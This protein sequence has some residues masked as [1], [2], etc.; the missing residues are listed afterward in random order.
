MRLPVAALIL[1]IATA[2][3]LAC[4]SCGGRKGPA[5]TVGATT[6]GMPPPTG[7]AGPLLPPEL[8]SQVDSVKAP[9]GVDADMFGAL[10]RRLA[11]ALARQ[12]EPGKS[13]LRPPEGDVNIVPS[14]VFEDDG[15]GGVQLVW[16]YYCVGDYDQSGAVAV[17]DLT[18]LAVH[19]GARVG[20]GD[21][22]APVVDGDGNGAVGIS[23][24]TPIAV[25][26]GVTC[27]GYSVK[28][29][30]SAD[31]HFD[32][33]I[34][35]MPRSEGL[36]A[37]QGRMRFEY[38]L[39]PQA[40][41]WYRVV[42]LDADGAEG[43]PSEPVQY[44]GPG[45]APHIVSVSP[46]TGTPGAVV[47]FSAEVTGV[48][49]MSFIWGFGDGAVPQVSYDE[50]PQVTLTGAG[51][52]LCSVQAENGFGSDTY[53]FTLRIGDPPEVTG[54]EPT[55]GVAGTEV[56]FDV[57]YTGEA[58][59]Y[60]W[61]F[62]GG[63]MPDES[64]LESPTVTLTGAG[65]YDASVVVGND[66]GE[67]L[68]TFTLSV[69]ASGGEPDIVSVAPLSGLTGTQVAFTATVNG[70][71]PF[72]YSWDFGSGANPAVSNQSSPVVTLLA[73][74]EYPCGLNVVNAFG[75]DDFP[76]TLQVLG[77]GEPPV[78]INAGPKEG[79]A[80]DEVTF[81]AVVQGTPPFTYAWDFDGGATPST[82]SEEAPVAT[83][84]ATTGDYSCSLTV[85]NEGGS[86]E[87]LFTLTVKPQGDY[88]EVE[89]ND[90]KEIANPLPD[91]PID[92]WYCHLEKDVD[93]D[94]F[95]SFEAEFGDQLDVTMT[96][97]SD[98]CD[99][100]MELWNSDEEVLA[101]S[102][103]TSDSE[104][105]TYTFGASGTY[106]LRC[107]VWSSGSGGG[108]YWVDITSTPTFIDEVEDNDTIGQ[109]NSLSFPLADFNASLG[110]GGYDGDD[111]DY[112]AISA[113]TD[114]FL[115]FTLT[116]ES[117]GYNID[118]E[119][120][121]AS[122]TVLETS[123]GTGTT[124]SIT[125][126][127]AAGG[128]YYLRCF[129]V[130]G[131]GLYTLAGYLGPSP[132]WQTITVDDST[133]DNLGSYSSLVV[134]GGNPGIFYKDD[135]NSD[136]FFAYCSTADG[137]GSWSVYPV[138][139]TSE[140]VGSW[141]NG[142]AVNGKPAAAYTGN[143]GTNITFAMC[144]SAD[145]S[146]TWYTSEVDPDGI[147]DP[148]VW[149]IDGRPA[150]SFR[151]DGDP[152][153]YPAFAINS[154]AD[155]NGSW[156]RYAIDQDPGGCYYTGLTALANGNPI[157]S[158]YAVTAGEIRVSRCSNSDGSGVWTASLVDEE[159]SGE[160]GIAIVDGRPAVVYERDG[161][162]WF[163]INS[164][165]DGSGNWDAK[166][167]V[168]AVGSPGYKSLMVVDG[169]PAVAFS[170]SSDLYYALNT[171]ADGS[172]VWS[173]TKVVLGARLG[174]N[175]GLNLVTGKPAVSFQDNLDDWIGFAMM[176]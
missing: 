73:P 37:S 116:Q 145:G 22:H 125:Y 141:L 97:D 165:A 133:S 157:V 101:Y 43:V 17:A 85:S 62:G 136:V 120:L 23:D 161:A 21:P 1:L 104:H 152:T 10:S 11:K 159:G 123:D 71:P 126:T 42:P 28:M 2:L 27:D 117:T 134:T 80:N 52:Y 154:S 107:Y 155:G 44:E 19:F 75:S 91:F 175:H 65:D 14:L 109:A 16:S 153:D 40:G 83:L 105:F 59:Y 5:P 74:G 77:G 64:D 146:G 47:T 38:P 156:T 143:P 9:P 173:V 176:E 13:V 163:A 164:A 139:V 128:T 140:S 124:E 150:L 63:A 50:N 95:F 170:T 8:Q 54:V 72:E 41:K 131:A 35:V 111:V 166:Y 115:D 100:D 88:D 129:T 25:N 93:D 70:T 96:L 171:A 84:S 86:D 24:I 36:D 174:S 130:S 160:T 57:T 53:G 33:E 142:A 4:P 20:E 3:L 31:G 144:S 76:F 60:D 39:V 58:T 56:T 98:A 51:E 30:D 45:G 168:A 67:D 46:Q 49:P 78:I 158:Y 135:S 48:K 113:D 121:D 81:S 118:L 99:R 89:P 169:K 167:E 172:G 114:D 92:G 108:D 12:L 110:P 79:H 90:T 6:H 132:Y 102:R 127:F 55:S 103:G 32:E 162:L 68:Y 61:D 69:V 94:D 82:S 122:E 29:A 119:L 7:A 138:D 148:C 66:F 112:F 34:G 137:L 87:F 15:A 106:Y 147:D 18:P 151:H 26:F 149:E